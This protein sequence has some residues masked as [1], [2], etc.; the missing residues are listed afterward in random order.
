MIFIVIV[1]GAMLYMCVCVCGSFFCELLYNT[2]HT[3]TLTLTTDKCVF[4][5]YLN[6]LLCFF[7]PNEA[8]RD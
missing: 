2:T 5:E 1:S 8:P 7:T 6:P 4:R 3:H